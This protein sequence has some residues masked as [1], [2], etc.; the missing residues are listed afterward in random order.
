MEPVPVQDDVATA[1]GSWDTAY[2]RKAVLLLGLGFG[3][4]GLDRW[5]IAPLFPF[6]LADLGLN[7]QDQGN[8]IGILGMAW[9]VFAIF[10][11]RLSDRIGHRKILIPAILLF[12]LLSGVS[13]MATGLAGLL[14]I[15]LLMGVME[16][17]YCPTSFTATA[18]AAHPSRRGFLQGLQ[19]SGFALFGLALG[20]IIATQLLLVVPSWRWVFWIVAAPGFIVGALLYVVLREPAQT[21]GGHIVGATQMTGRWLDVF[22]SRNIVL[23]MC[24]LFCAMT[25]VF[26]LGAMVPNYLIDYLKLSPTQMGFV[27]SGLGFGGFVGQF[28]VPGLSDLFGRRVMAM[29]GFLGAS[30]FVYLLMQTG[31]NPPALFALLFMVSFFCLGNVALITGPISTESAPPGLVSSAIGMVV[32]AGEIFGG[33]VAPI[34]AGGVAQN[35][36]IQNVLWVALFGVSLGIVVSVFIKETAPR[37]VGLAKTV[38]ASLA[39]LL[40]AQ[41]V[42]AQNLVVTNARILDG[43]GRVIERGAVVVRDGRIVSVD[44]GTVDARGAR[45]IDAQGKTLMPGFID[46]H[47]HIVRGE[48]QQWLKE[49]AATRMQE[50]L[51]AGFTT[52][53]SAGDQPDAILELRRRL[54]AG[55]MKGPRVFAAGRIPLARPAAPAGGSGAAPAG[56]GARFDVSRPPRR[57]TQPAAAIPAQ[58]TIQAVNAVVK[59]GFDYIKTVIIVTPGGPEKDTLALIATEG[60]KHNLPTITHAVTVIDTLAAVEAGVTRLV[61]TPHI[62]RLDEDP[63]AV[64]KIATA[65]IPMTSTLAI[66][67]PHFGP[68]QK[69][70]FRDGLPFPWDTI[71]S[72]G[73]GPVNARLL[74]N[75][76]ISY[77]YGTDTSW[78]P[79]ETLADELRAL[80]VVFSPAE[81]V[82][83]MTKNAATS[84]IKGDQLGT[85]EPGKIADMVIL[86]GDP[87]ADTANLLNVAT[88]IKGGEVV[89]EKR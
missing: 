59:A 32:G 1:R 37:K 44:S 85:L 79:R 47:R 78:H 66:F 4:V 70:L 2:E 65:G 52:V 34:I 84:A 6:M 48:G 57:P 3:L 25:C 17:S 87:L 13:G 56:D 88:V 82:T 15:R 35:Y 69:P 71:S 89:L 38:V 68:D 12:S 72:A 27:M 58:E 14:A 19:Q 50:F 80:R 11:G 45:V 49:Q 55:E 22:K 5:I 8:I 67:L 41:S 30:V 18:S 83:I 40:C 23:S 61:H 54:Q 33:G 28:G 86:Y 74:W 73:Q 36:G 21:Q 60:K 51:D 7:L 20:P 64:Q 31:A 24:C 81:I 43:T 62:G 29:L 63:A 75:A 10:S 16:G 53:V 46:A 77:G 26:V 39:V 42:S 9:G 76:G